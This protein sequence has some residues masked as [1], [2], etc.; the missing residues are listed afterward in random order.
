MNN[1]TEQAALPSGPLIEHSVD[2]NTDAAI[3]SEK[4]ELAKYESGT[5]THPHLVFIVIMWQSLLHCIR[6]SLA[7]AVNI[8]SVLLAFT[9]CRF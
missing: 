4:E 5:R 9:C 8:F 1:G 7:P 3:S 6:A 2:D